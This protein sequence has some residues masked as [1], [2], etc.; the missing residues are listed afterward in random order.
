MK[1]REFITLLRRRGGIA[2]SGI[3]SSRASSRGSD[4]CHPARPRAASWGATTHS[5][6]GWPANW[7]CRREKHHHRIPLRRRTIRPARRARRRAGSAQCGDHRC[8]RYAGVCG[9]RRRPQQFRSLW[10]PPCRTLWG[11]SGWSPKPCTA[12]RQRYRNSFTNDGD[13]REIAAAAQGSRPEGRTRG[14]TVEPRQCGFPAQMLKETRRAGAALGLQLTDFGTR[15][16]PELDRSSRRSPNRAPMR[17]WFS[18]IRSSFS[19]EA[20]S[21]ALPKGGVCRPCTG[22]RTMRRPAVS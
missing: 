13:G 8:G 18:P 16:P 17:C 20:R 22:S 4:T 1:R 6:K 7:V 3:G 12:R 9:P 14:G 11:R 19:I 2:G 10:S 21:S 5:G 15:D